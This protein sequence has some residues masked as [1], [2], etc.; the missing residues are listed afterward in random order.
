MYTACRLLQQFYDTHPH[1]VTLVC[2]VTGTVRGEPDTH[3][4][5]LVPSDDVP[6]M[7][8]AHRPFSPAQS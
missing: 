7:P 2:A 6:G 5:R 4:V 8:M 3:A 1:K